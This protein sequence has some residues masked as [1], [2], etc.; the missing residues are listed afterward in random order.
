MEAMTKPQIQ[1]KRIFQHS[2]SDVWKAISTQE[3]LEQWL[4]EVENFELKIGHQFTLKTKPQ[5]GFD[6]IIHC[7]ILEFTPLE[8]LSYTWTSNALPETIVSFNL[9]A[10]DN[11][12]TMLT[13]SHDGFQGFSGWFTKQILNFGWKKLIS[14]NLRNYLQA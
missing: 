1:I 13:L 12:K 11:N 5:G 14:K 8:Y 4:M 7:R 9:K 3:A 6:G 2:K 10:L